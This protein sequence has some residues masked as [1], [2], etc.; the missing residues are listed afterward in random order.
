MFV[1]QYNNA[2]LYN[3]TK[4]IQPNKHIYLDNS[5][6]TRCDER[7]LEAM[8]PYFCDE[9]GN[10]GSRNHRFGWRAEDAATNARQTIA[11]L[12]GAKNKQEIIFTSGATESNNIAIRGAAKYYRRNY[13]N[14]QHI[15]TNNIEHK[16]VLNS[17]KDL[18]EEGYK[19]TYLEVSSDGLIDPYAVANAITDETILVSIAWVHNEIG[20]IQN[21]REIGRLCRERGVLLHTDCAQGVGR[22]PINVYDDYVDLMSISGHKV[23]GPK[24]IGALYIRRGVRLDPIISGGG[25]ERGL[26]SGTLPVALCVGLAKAMEIAEEMRESEWHRIKELQTYMIENLFK[27]LPVIELNG[28]SME[29]IPHNVNI[30]FS[31]VEGESLMIYMGDIAVSSGSACTSGSLEPSYVLEG[32]GASEELVHT[33]IRIVFGRYN[34]FEDAQIATN[35]IIHAVNTLRDMSPVWDEYSQK[36]TKPTCHYSCG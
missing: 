12:I 25:Q 4:K 24:G 28:N 10:A 22:I 34:T 15:I 29:R 26:R 36:H 35:N 11:D 14:K 33:A 17:C 7:V 23:Y 13:S 27:A 19:V 18:E 5:A 30:S 2:I 6:T 20:V 32:L 8:L 16:C 31:C 3:G 1:V 9:Y 21:I